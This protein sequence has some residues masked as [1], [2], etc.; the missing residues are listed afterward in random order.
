LSIQREAPLPGEHSR[1]VATELGL[2]AE[3]VDTLLRTG[4]ISQTG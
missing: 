4:A 3:Q 1:E 2:T